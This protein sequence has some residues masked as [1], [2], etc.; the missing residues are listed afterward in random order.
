MGSEGQ[1]LEDQNYF[2]LKMETIAKF[3][4][5]Q[6]SLYTEDQNYFFTYD[7]LIKVE[8][9]NVQKIKTILSLFYIF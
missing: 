6:K 9:G 8:N 2:L 5:H 3:S 4:E 7:L 1:I